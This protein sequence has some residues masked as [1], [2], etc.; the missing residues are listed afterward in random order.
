MLGDGC[1]QEEE[2]TGLP[3]LDISTPNGPISLRL[4]NF[5]VGLYPHQGEREG[6]PIHLQYL[7]SI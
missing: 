2:R 4:P 1:S 6:V 7:S 3:S 5:P